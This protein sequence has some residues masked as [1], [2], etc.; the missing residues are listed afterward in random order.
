MAETGLL[1]RIR[2]F[3]VP[4]GRG[5][6]KRA[7][8]IGLFFGLITAVSAVFLM[9][10]GLFRGFDT[11]LQ[12]L[13]MQIGYRPMPPY[14][15]M[16]MVKKDQ[17]TSQLINNNPGR[18]EFAS[19]FSFLG[20]K[21]TVKKGGN[22]KKQSLQ[23]L[24]IDLGLFRDIRD[25]PFKMSFTE[26]CGFDDSDDKKQQSRWRSSSRQA[27]DFFKANP[28]APGIN[29]FITIEE[30]I[31]PTSGMNAF[32]T[33]AGGREF[34]ILP[35]LAGNWHA[36]DCIALIKQISDP[37]DEA[38]V[39]EDTQKL[40][41]DELQLLH[42]W[43]A[44]FEKL[45]RAGLRISFEFFPNAQTAL[46][47]LLILDIA[48]A[49]SEYI[50][51]PAGIIGFDF[52]LQGENE[53]NR[54]ID[55]LLQKAIQDSESRIV[56]A[57][58]TK[59]EENETRIQHEKNFEGGLLDVFRQPSLVSRQVMPH[60]KF[61]RGN[62]SVAMIDVAM[63]SK[64]YVTEMPLF[65]VNE[66]K[67]QMMPSF[68]LK[69]AMLALDRKYPHQQPSYSEAMHNAFLRI[70]D[71]YVAG[72]FKGPLVINDLA[73]PVNSHGRML[74]DFVGS[75]NR[76]KEN[77]AVIP[78]VS[79]YEC[80]ERETLEKMHAA[81]PSKASLKPDHAHRRTLGFQSNK[82]DKIILAGP[83][84]V[85]DFDFYPTPIDLATPWQIAK[86]PLMGVE[87]HANAI[88]NIL[89]KKYLKHP[90]LW[91]TMLA[92]LLS[93]LLLG[94]L[95][96]HSP[97]VIGAFL[98]LA[99]MGGA[100]WQSYES[101]HTARQV[102]HVGALL[103]SYPFIWI[104]ATLANYIR[105]RLQAKVTKDMFSRFVAADVVQYMLD[106][107]E[108]VKP[109]GEKVELTIFFSDVAGFTS[110]SEA[111]T[112]EELVVLLNEYLGAMTDLLFEYGGTL[113]KFIGDAVMAFWNFPRQQG[114]HAVRGCLCALAMQRK[115]N[116]L[117]IGWAERGLP[118]VSARA[119]LNTA[120]VVV[121]YM[122]SQKA[123]MN[124]TCMGDGVNL[125]SR[126]EG[127]NKEYGTDLMISDATY[128]RAKHVVTARFLDFLAVKGKKEPVKVF[129]LV[130]EKG[131]EPPE[132]A[133]LSGMYDQAIQLHLD[134][135]WDEAIETF[136]K[137]LARWPKD[138]PS[139]TYLARC[140][141]YKQHPPP[142]G[143]D[144]RYI[145]THK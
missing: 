102:F 117:Q 39:S 74:I 105:Q 23:L 63:G 19:L 84:E 85:S 108:L 30:Q 121:G 95:L 110:I 138:G 72:R 141:E 73:I 112:P 34:M 67:R 50:V 131:K 88:I 137:I 16:I 44:F 3:V 27:R 83:F 126:L 54:Q 2:D 114:D 22:T 42:R 130:S 77:A 26:W 55:E 125:A 43:Q 41:A 47:M 145:L 122:G 101:Y 79:M 106:N 64:S 28:N 20:K 136:E 144:G 119:G 78:S 92:L 24:K 96:D 81:M 7:Y 58:Y 133:E 18:A 127:A 31:W 134:R 48:P 21:Q 59:L 80:F 9:G 76:G 93:C 4:S 40:Y 66:E 115:I 12:G 45:A 87:I 70:Y 32:K 53:D 142:E 10:A 57:G 38:P 60:E 129:E 86:D 69:I 140:Q 128:Q 113:D 107:P 135:Q 52:V 100:F 11:Y 17:A 65:I 5:S 123:Q 33:L 82:A 13:I 62:S 91:H 6:S 71:D 109:G 104:L 143:W 99:F 103:M 51:G 14:R 49:A 118:R 29:S 124:F 132:W 75:T 116:E 68:S 36:E 89:E 35:T 46:R 37:D 97:P 120:G 56:L 98:T 8:R 90:N 25:L 1:K 61:V 139:A 111:L 15:D 94:F